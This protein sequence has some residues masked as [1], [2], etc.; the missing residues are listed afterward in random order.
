MLLFYWKSRHK[1]G[2]KCFMLLGF[3]IGH[4][5]S[6]FSMNFNQS[7][8]QCYTCRAPFRGYTTLKAPHSRSI[9]QRE[10]SL[11]VF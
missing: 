7:I 3:G 6:T 2:I 4:V 1:D 8:N 5:L 10:E 11:N 9:A